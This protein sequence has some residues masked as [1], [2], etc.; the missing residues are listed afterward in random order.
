MRNRI[1][2]DQP[3]NPRL[4]QPANLPGYEALGVVT[5]GGYTGALLR[6]KRT[7]VFVM[8]N[9]GA[10]RALDQTK[11]KAALGIRRGPKTTVDGKACNVYLDADSLETASRLGDGN[12][13][14][15]IRKALEIAGK[16]SRKI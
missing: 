10:T 16:D 5:Q 12:V 7:G 4:Y 2:I 11:V 1:E 13:S 14:A 6:Q 9:A 15:G 8:A 3:G